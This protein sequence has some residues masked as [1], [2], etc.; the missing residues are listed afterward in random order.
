MRRRAVLVV[1]VGT[2]SVRAAL[3]GEEGRILALESKS[4][5]FFS[6]YPGWAEQSPEEWFS[7]ACTCMEGVLK[8]S[9][10]VEVL[11]LGVSAQMHAVVP[12]DGRGELLLSR[13]PIWCDKRSDEVCR[14][15]HEILPPEEQIERTA[16]LLIPNWLAPKM[17]WIRE[18]F[19]EV[20]AKTSCFLAAKD[21]LNFRFTG[22]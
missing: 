2:E 12:V 10:E 1:D 8:R 21:Y 15:I 7:A 18:H 4:L 13:V 20:Y 22:A 11:A 17:R 3:V 6:P 14:R 9:A 19:P 16:N 5:E